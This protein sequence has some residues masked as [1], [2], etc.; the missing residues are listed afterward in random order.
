LHRRVTIENGKILYIFEGWDKR[1]SNVLLIEK[2]LMFK[3]IYV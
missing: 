2:W 3:D 1:A